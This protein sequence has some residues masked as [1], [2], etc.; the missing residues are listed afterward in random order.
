MVRRR[1]GKHMNYALADQ[2]IV[3]LILNALAH[4]SEGSGETSSTNPNT[5]ER[6]R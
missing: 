1:E 4:A 3:D 6:S 5:K 2:H